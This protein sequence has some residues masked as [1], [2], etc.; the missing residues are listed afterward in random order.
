MSNSNM[1]LA[2]GIIATTQQE[3]DWFE[4]PE[5]WGFFTTVTREELR[6]LQNEVDIFEEQQPILRDVF[7]FTN[8]LPSEDYEIQIMVDKENDTIRT[9]A[10][11]VNNITNNT[12][13]RFVNNFKNPIH[14]TFDPLAENHDE[15]VMK[16]SL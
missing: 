15:P 14:E 3:L 16:I 13:K 9:S 5:A 8:S 6:Q 1:K 2:K 12:I 11:I 4:D 7:K 10:I